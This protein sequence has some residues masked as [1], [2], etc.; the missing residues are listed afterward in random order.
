MIPIRSCNT[1]QAEVDVKAAAKAYHRVWLA[2]E[3][4]ACT[5]TNWVPTLRAVKG[6]PYLLLSDSP[7]TIDEREWVSITLVAAGWSD[8]EVAAV[9]VNRSP[10]SCHGCCLFRSVAIPCEHVEPDASEVVR[11]YCPEK[12]GTGFA[13]T[14]RGVVLWKPPCLKCTSVV[15]GN[16]GCK[17]ALLVNS[18]RHCHSRVSCCACTAPDYLGQAWPGQLSQRCA[19][20]AWS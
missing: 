20:Y 1:L 7:C 5:C 16:V 17:S 8:K 19:Y 12:L 6:L 13:S 4:C 2:A 10:C 11:T 14:C 3:G 15:A 9:S 18:Q